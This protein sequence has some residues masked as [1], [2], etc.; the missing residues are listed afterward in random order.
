MRWA[1]I[2]LY[3]YNI[4]QTSCVSSKQWRV[5]NS[6][7]PKLGFSMTGEMEFKSNTSGGFGL[8]KVYKKTTI[9]KPN[10]PG[11]VGLETN[12]IW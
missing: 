3:K 5:I 6:A 11:Q 8:K 2:K 1:A 10:Q 12:C 4:K 7:F 9:E